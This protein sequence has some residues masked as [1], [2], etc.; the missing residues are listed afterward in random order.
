MPCVAQILLV[1]LPQLVQLK[2]LELTCFE[3]RDVDH[4]VIGCLTF[5]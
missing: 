3:V 5:R 2:H 4:S 1:A